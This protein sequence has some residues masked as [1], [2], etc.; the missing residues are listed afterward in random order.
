MFHPRNF[1]MRQRTEVDAHNDLLNP[2]AKFS[3]L[4]SY[5]KP[6]SFIWYLRR[7]EQGILFPT[8]LPT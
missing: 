7:F 3:G 5:W 1:R 4:Q 8:G 2:L 6:S